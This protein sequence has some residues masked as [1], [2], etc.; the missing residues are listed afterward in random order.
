MSNDQ[1]EDLY[2]AGMLPNLSPRD[3]AEVNRLAIKQISPDIVEI[4]GI[5][6][7]RELFRQFGGLL[8]VGVDFR[9]V[10]RQD[11]VVAVHRL[12]VPLPADNYGLPS[13]FA[14][15]DLVTITAK[16]AGVNFSDGKVR[17]V[18]PL[19]EG[20]AIVDSCDVQA[21]PAAGKD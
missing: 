13:R 8:P 11:G 14:I 18:L 20:I 7:S 3:E 5:K 1:R 6:Y 10:R 12:D 19:G 21:A 4:Y 9:L 2:N 16:I 15:G 17:Y